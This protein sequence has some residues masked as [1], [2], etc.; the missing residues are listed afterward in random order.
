MVNIF[1]RESHKI[2]FIKRQADNAA[3]AFHSLEEIK[4]DEVYDSE[5]NWCVVLPVPGVK[6]VKL[7]DIQYHLKYH[8][9]LEWSDLEVI[10]EK[11]NVK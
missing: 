9:R 10:L 5:L 2:R 8:S 6:H 3:V 4:Q 11:H 7:E 1:D